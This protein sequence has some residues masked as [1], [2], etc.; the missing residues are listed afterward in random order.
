ME[1][2]KTPGSAATSP[3]SNS[4]IY[5]VAFVLVLVAAV[6]GAYYLGLHR[7]DMVESVLTPAV[8]MQLPAKEG[9]RKVELPRV[10]PGG[11]GPETVA[12]VA[13]AV[14]PS[15]VNIDVYG[16]VLTPAA[17]STDSDFYFNG[18]RIAP[19]KSL[20]IIPHAQKSGTGSGVIIRTDGYILTNNHVVKGTD[21]LKATLSD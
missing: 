12:D 10:V 4:V 17:S 19:F 5:I 7:R 2:E 9:L 20:P 1:A 18:T 14:S 15:V 13:A 6:L 21:R 8:P 16:Q 11:L 3:V